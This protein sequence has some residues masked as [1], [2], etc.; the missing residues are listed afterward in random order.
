MQLKSL[1]DNFK[2]GLSLNITIIDLFQ[3][4]ILTGVIFYLCKTFYRTR[5]WI[6]I[7]GL[8]AIG[9]AYLIVYATHMTVLQSIMEGL[10]SI[11][12]VSIVIMFQPDLQRLVESV[13]KR[14][15]KATFNS[16]IQKPQVEDNWAS[17]RT[18]YKIVSACQDMSEAKTGALIVLERGIPLKEYID[19]G[20]SIK[21]DVSN[22]L[23][24]NIFE[25]NTPLHDG[26][27]IISGDKVQAATC[28]LPLT[29]SE[30][31]SKNLGTRHRAAIGISEITDSVAVVVSEETGAMSICV[32]GKI[33]HNIDRTKLSNELHKFCEKHDEKLIKASTHS[34]PKFLKIIPPILAILT[35][36][37]ILNVNDPVV[38]KR[39][40]DVPVVIQNENILTDKNQSFTIESGDEISVILK[41]H[42]SVIEEM[43]ASDIIATADIGEMSIVNA[44][45]INVT[46]TEE[47]ADKVEI[48]PKTNV[49]KLALENLSQV[50]IPI[51]VVVEGNSRDKLIMMEVDGNNTLTVMATESIAKTLN[52]AIVVV[53]ITGKDSDFTITKEA[54]VYDRNGNVVSASKLSFNNQVPLKGTAYPTKTVP[55]NIELGEVAEDET[56][57][58]E[59]NSFEPE[60][61]SI[62]IAA[63][64]SILKDIESLDLVIPP[65]EGLETVTSMAFK[66]EN[67]LPEN[68]YLG[69]TQDKELPLTVSITKYQKINVY[70]NKDAIAITGG[71]EW[72]DTYVYEDVPPT[73]EVLV[74]ASKISTD[75]ITLTLLAPSIEITPD[76][77]EHTSKLTIAN[78]EGVYL[79]SDIDI[80]Y[81]NSEKEGE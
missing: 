50:E 66:L 80:T 78:I 11:L 39:F 76:L 58:Y 61:L 48:V 14:S 53:D 28:Y 26:A 64:E 1:F 22:Q 62:Q 9:A 54:V 52:K 69:P 13:G 31:I 68:V 10:F 65:D 42:R 41:G 70:F 25:K 67:Y 36:I 57:L 8:L 35:C 33:Q 75:V 60:D 17:D 43:E 73:I 40:R 46:T 56:Y 71:N 12:M 7:K 81:H 77:G 23:L 6:L 45:P 37:F 27:V 29:L 3:M 44:I 72:I 79:N 2:W 51:E 15:L 30:D 18:I 47:F 74:D 21:A 34:T 49:L 59:L 19:L 5:A 55:L 20:I 63:E 4:L 38:T 16:I 24:I 32:N